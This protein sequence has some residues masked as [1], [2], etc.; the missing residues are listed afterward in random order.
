V[1]CSLR[2]KMTTL[3]HDELWCLLKEGLRMWDQI[4]AWSPRLAVKCE[5]GEVTIGGEIC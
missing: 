3:C 5:H 4:S 1:M 2:M